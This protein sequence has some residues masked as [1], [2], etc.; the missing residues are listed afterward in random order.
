M[1][2][3]TH[4]RFVMIFF[5][6]FCI[7]VHLSRNARDCTLLH[8]R[9]VNSIWLLIKKVLFLSVELPQVGSIL[10]FYR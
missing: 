10:C 2:A 1:A 8:A 7:C 4:E 5:C 6:Q 3:T 9:S